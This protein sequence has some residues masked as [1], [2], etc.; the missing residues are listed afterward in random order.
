[1]NTWIC[2][3]AAF[4]RFIFFYLLHSNLL[5]LSESINNDAFM[6]HETKIFRMDQYLIN[7]QQTCDGAA[8]VLLQKWAQLDSNNLLCFSLWYHMPYVVLAN[9]FRVLDWTMKGFYFKDV[10]AECTLSYH[11]E[12]FV[13]WSVQWFLSVNDPLLNKSSMQ[14]DMP[15]SL[16]HL[17]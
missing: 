16:M 4:G 12:S 14:W 3:L 15:K 6:Q 9:N 7:I 17:I 1:M 8:L 10:L 5:D 11:I 13:L 2:D